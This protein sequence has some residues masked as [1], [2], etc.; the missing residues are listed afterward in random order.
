MSTLMRSVTVTIA[1]KGWL[2]LCY[3][4]QLHCKMADEKVLIGTAPSNDSYLR[5]DRIMEAVEKTGAQAVHPGY[6]FLSENKDFAQLLA[7]NNVEFLGPGTHAIEVRLW[8]QAAGCRLPC[9]QS[10]HQLPNTWLRRWS[11]AVDYGR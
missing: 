10:R 9:I 4:D 3:S 7:S 6:G 11:R 5:M 2:T 8:L 1:I